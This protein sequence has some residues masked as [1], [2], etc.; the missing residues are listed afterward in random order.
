MGILDSVA[1]NYPADTIRVKINSGNPAFPFPQFLEYT[2]GKS[3]AKNNAVGVTHADMEKAIREAYQ[4][5]MHRAIYTGEVLGTGANQVKYIKFNPPVVPQGYG[6]FVSEGD[7][8]A[9]LAAAYMGDKTTFDGLWC[10]IHDNRAQK[11]IRYLDCTPLRMNYPN[12]KSYVMGWTTDAT[13][14]ATSSYPND[15]ATDGDVDIALA[16][17]IAYKQWGEWMNVD[18]CGAATNISYRQEALTMLTAMAD[19][20]YYSQNVNGAAAGIKGFLTGDIGIDGYI[21]SGNTWNEVTDWRYSAANT[22]Y[23]WAKAHPDALGGSKSPYVDYMAPAYFNQFSK[24]LMAN[25][26]SPWQISQ[27]R[28]SEASSDWVIRQMYTKGYIASAGNY[29]FAADDGSSIT[30]GPFAGGEDFRASWRTIL[31]YVWHGNPDS[32]WNPVTHQKIAGVNTFEYDM[33]VR[34]ADFLKYPRTLPSASS[35]ANCSTLGAS[36][37]PSCPNWRGVAQIKQQYASNG[38][39]LAN[40]GVNWMAGTGGPAAVASGDL[41]ITAELYRQCELVWDDASALSSGMTDAQRYILST[42]KYFHGW[43]RLLGML[44]TSGNLHSPTSMTGIANMKVYMSV[45]KTFGYEGDLLTYS[46]SYRNYGTLT[47][48]GVSIST[49]L[50]NNYQ[51]VSVS[52]GG[53]FSGNKITWSIGNVPGFQSATGILPTTGT[54]QFVV[55]IKTLPSAQNVCLTST[56][57]SLNAPNWISNEYP[58]NASYTMERNCV[59]LLKD[60]VLAI[61]KTTDRAAMNP[62]DIVNFTLNFENK[63]GSNLWLN[64]GRDRV[65]IS[66]GN[67]HPT[68]GTSFYQFYRIWHSAHE[69]YINLGNYRVSYFMNDAAAIGLYNTTT[70]PTGWDTYVDNQSD[71]NKYGYNPLTLPVNQQL[72]FIYQKMPWGSDAFGSWNQR[73]VTQFANVLSAPSTHIYDKLDSDYLIHKGVKGPGF[74]RTRFESKPSSDLTSRLADDWSYSPTMDV[75]SLDGQAKRF[76]PISP[77]YTDFTTKFAPVVVNNYSKDICDPDVGNYSRV[78]VEEFDGYVWRRIAGNGPLP[79]RETYDV[80]V[81]DSIPIQLTWNGFTNATT[82]G[83]SATYT[84]LTGNPKFSGYVKW[85]VPVMLTGEKGMLSYS[86]IAKNPPCPSPDINFV[87]NGWMWSS[88]DSPDSSTVPLLLTCNPVPPTAPAQT[89]LFKTAD[90]VSVNVGDVITYKVKFINNDGSTATWKGLS[91]STT[92]WQ[93]FGT[94]TTMPDLAKS[95]LSLDQNSNVSKPGANGY[96]FGHKK[97]HGK[98]GYIEATIDVT[99]SSGLSFIYRYTGGT[100]GQASFQGVRLDITP[101]PSGQNTINFTVYNNNTVIATLTNIAYGG[102]YDPIN[103]RTELIND[104]LYIWTNDYTGAPLKVISGITHT[105]AGFAGLYTGGSQQTLTAWKT[106]FDSAFDIAITDNLPASLKNPIN[107]TPSTATG[108]LTGNVIAWPVV[109]GPLLAGDS[110]VR[111]FKVTV[112]TCSN[113]ITNIANATTFGINTISAQHVVY[114]TS[115]LSAELLPISARKNTDHSALIQWSCPT[116]ANK[117]CFFV[118]RSSDGLEFTLLDKVYVG[119][120]VQNGGKYAYTDEHPSSP[121]QFYRIT[122][123]NSNGTLVRSS[124]ERVDFKVPYS[125]SI[126]PNPYEG[127]ATVS[128]SDYSPSVIKIF[129]LSGQLV[130]QHETESASIEIGRGLSNGVYTVQVSQ[131]NTVYHLRIVHLK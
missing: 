128:L 43:Y 33:A 27:F 65:I 2:A 108:V 32:T 22:A 70:N 62:G 52:N 18:P 119:N 82:L 124:I 40:Y 20:F 113:F 123:L 17:V 4:I 9:L 96:A 1:Q 73:I 114:C 7:G 90:K 129:D 58:N 49:M 101:N 23:P 39:V 25:G 105:A 12:G 61:V 125:V 116:L 15:A 93:T 95:I 88:V 66:Y 81:T 48:S 74:T 92:D 59:D 10:W 87:N 57:T 67:N 78:L 131:N 77:T 103:I 24:F 47:A 84:A 69:A 11:V 121:F 13:V 56:I 111:T 51:L 30:F 107:Y 112:T 99:N 86:T 38:S 76:F 53:S 50:D 122:A 127:S 26:G 98:N 63:S 115:A 71:L 64:G 3:L 91:T 126:S 46:I 19:T 83:V 110:L 117:S 100:V 28:R 29:Q 8:Y 45:D 94:G 16:L 120:G 34:H 44:V 106:H 42:P 31:N 41:D 68:N 97:S 89:S 14:P 37:D 79:G 60:R 6:T 85:T 75:N 102:S 35:S 118:E 80:V 36:P 54:V 55:Q 130:E 109:P 72:K 21:K 104:K 5:M